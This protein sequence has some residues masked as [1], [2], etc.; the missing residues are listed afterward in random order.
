MENNKNY[1]QF[2]ALLNGLN[3]E[4]KKKVNKCKDVN[5]F[6]LLLGELGIAL[7]D[8]LLEAAFVRHGENDLHIKILPGFQEITARLQRALPSDIL[9]KMLRA[10]RDQ[11]ENDLMEVVGISEVQNAPVS[12]YKKFD[13]AVLPVDPPG[14]GHMDD[15]A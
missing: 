15:V 7:P 10:R 12:L 14:A 13:L 4:Q 1:E 9:R 5:E 3:D 2:N 6:M 8:E 11:R